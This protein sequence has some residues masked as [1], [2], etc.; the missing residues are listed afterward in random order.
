MRISYRGECNQA[1][2]FASWQLQSQ[3][4]H[5]QAVRVGNDS[6]S[7]VGKESMKVI[8]KA[9]LSKNKGNMGMF[10]VIILLFYWGNI[11]TFTKVLTIYHS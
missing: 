4:K 10:L 1:Q 5:G 9:M 8:S 2:W 3:N 6:L 7:L 11:V